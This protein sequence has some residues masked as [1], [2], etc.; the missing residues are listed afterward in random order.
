VV[1]DVRDQALD[2]TPVGTYYV[3]QWSARETAARMRLL[4]RTSLAAE[5]VAGD[6]RRAVSR[7]DPG[8][9]VGEI[10]TLDSLLARSLS[11][12]RYRTLLVNVFAGASLLLAAVGIFGVTL[13]VMLRRRRELGVRLALGARHTRLIGGLLGATAAGA[14]AGLAV[15][16]VLTAL[17]TPAMSEYLY[18]LPARDAATYA[19]SAAL[20]FLVSLAAAGVP[21]LS[22]ARVNV[23]DVLRED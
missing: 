17:V 18:Q 23:V 4:M 5:L 10:A 16:I 15:G 3:S 20:L 9:P 11:A 7:V 19:G 21:A 22:V 8:V 13:R 12:E 6:V 1:A 2:R 14:C